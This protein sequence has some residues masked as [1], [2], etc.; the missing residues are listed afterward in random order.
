MEPKVFYL[1]LP[2]DRSGSISKNRFRLELLWGVGKMLD[3][4]EDDREFTMVFDYACDIEVHYKDGF[5]FFQIKTHGTSKNY[6]TNS[7]TKVKGEGSIL[8]K[9]YVLNKD[10][11]NQN[12]QLAVVSNIPYNSMP[13]DTLTNCF[14]SLPA[15]EQAKI[16]VALQQELGISNVD[17]SKLYYIQT[18]MNLEKPENEIRGKLILSFEKVKH[19][20]P[21]NPNALYRLVVDTVQEKACYEYSSKEYDEI[22][23][24]K[25]LSRDEFDRML[26]L[27]VE[28]AKTGI[29]AAS[30]YIDSIQ[31]I[32]ERKIYKKALPNVLKMLSTT[33]TFRKI[34]LSVA[35]FL[36][37]SEE[38]DDMENTI[39]KLTDTFHAAFLPE[40]TN[41]E[42]VVFYIVVIKR[43]EEGV[44]DDEDDI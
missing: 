24:L 32:R 9:L 26:D 33:R 21:T 38:L 17:F 18:G 11:E 8:G 44:Y 10:A 1:S 27:H 25:G 34:E 28:N 2:H 7:L 41:A 15:T 5:E 29:K 40:I 39:D 35:A 31:G 12:I 23:C 4:M 20:E 37:S 36:N 13:S 3:L 43:F 42:K 19:C 6:T 16:A 14:S 30:D 22:L